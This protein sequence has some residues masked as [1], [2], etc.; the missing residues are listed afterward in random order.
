[1]ANLNFDPAVLLR[2]LRQ[3]RINLSR[4]WTVS[5]SGLVMSA[6]A[7][8]GAALL[9]QFLLVLWLS[10]SRMRESLLAKSDFRLQFL[11]NATDMD[12][13]Q[14]LVAA[15]QFPSVSSIA[16]VPREK[17]MAAEKE[18]HP[19]IAK[20]M[21]NNA[22][23]PFNDSAIVTIASTATFDEF[24]AFVRHP[25]WSG[26]IAP[27]TFPS[28]AARQEEIRTVLDQAG[29]GS[30]AAFIMFAAAGAAVLLVAIELVRRS[31]AAR[32]TDV[33]VERV[34]G[35][36]ETYV[37][38]PFATEI[39]AL[40]AIA[41]FFSLACTALLAFAF[42]SS[43]PLIEEARSLAIARGPA[44]IAIEFAALPVI[45]LA[46]AIIGAGRV[47]LFQHGSLAIV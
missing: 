29:A 41:L 30:S 23:N 46:A 35:A 37:I 42:P 13:Q 27:A 44:V 16:Y 32:G 2:G 24:A 11:Q 9:A 38:L 40:L 15:R 47:H 6:M 34:S 43:I 3:G 17:A 5:R 20:L 21:E 45:G 31:A 1:M 19:D 8:F 22:I 33:F 4:G 18:M 12:T 10:T 25:R 14:F 26:I 7:L 28:M 36:D 39:T